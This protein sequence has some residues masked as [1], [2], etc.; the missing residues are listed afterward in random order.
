MGFL[1][2]GAVW[3]Y[4]GAQHGV[5]IGEAWLAAVKRYER[6]VLAGR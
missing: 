3:D 4:H 6:E 1:S 2:A 5:P